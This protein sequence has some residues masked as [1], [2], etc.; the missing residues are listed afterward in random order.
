MGA[1]IFMTRASAPNAREAF[2]SAVQNA[3]HEYGHRG[4]TGTIAEKH[5]FAVLTPPAGE[6]PR[7]FAQRLL[8]DDDD[9][10][11]DKWGPAACV[12]L[13]PNPKREGHRVWLFFGWASS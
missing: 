12:D 5:D 13:G 1:D 8:D 6:D 4:Y 9:R 11:S 10:V 3:L 2:T 7:A